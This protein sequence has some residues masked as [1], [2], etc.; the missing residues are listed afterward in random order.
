[1]RVRSAY[2]E[3]FEVKIGVYQRLML[4]RLLFAIAV[5]STTQN[6]KR[7]VT[8][9]ILHADDLVIMSKIM[10]DLKQRL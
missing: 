6:S 8:N 2:S 10:Q 7:N 9:E 1:M 3:E 5:N 4:L